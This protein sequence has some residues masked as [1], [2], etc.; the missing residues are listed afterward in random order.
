M[1]ARIP[2]TK[3]ELDALL[4]RLEAYA[5]DWAERE[6]TTFDAAVLGEPPKENEEDGSIW[7]VP[8]IDSKRVVSLLGELE[9]MIGEKCK[10]PVSAI[11]S[12]G[13]TSAAD[14]V[15]KLFPRLREKCPDA[16]K[17]GIVS[18]VAAPVVA[19]RAPS[20]QVLP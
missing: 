10:L 6:C 20:A 7:D 1:T 18:A 12:G 16:H 13:Y 2:P 14:L 19:G 9:K 3:A 11:K 17:P 4:P 5:R 15:A 8:A